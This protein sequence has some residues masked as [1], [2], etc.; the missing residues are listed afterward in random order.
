MAGLCSRNASICPVGHFCRDCLGVPASRELPK[1]P[2]SS[3][4]PNGARVDRCMHFKSG[5]A[6]QFRSFPLLRCRPVLQEETQHLARGVRACGIGKPTG[7][8]APGPR[9]TGLLH[10]PE[11]RERPTF[12]PA[13]RHP[14]VWISATPAAG[15]LGAAQVFIRVDGARRD[16]TCVPDMHDLVVFAVEDDRGHRAGRSAAWRSVPHGDCGGRCVVCRAP[17]QP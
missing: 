17:R 14:D 12:S 13:M 11:F 9:M 16:E 1:D 4:R 7:S 10:D 2:R 15:Q 5:C 8:A 3:V 6:G